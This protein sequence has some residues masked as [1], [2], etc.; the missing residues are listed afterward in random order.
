[1]VIRNNTQKTETRT[2]RTSQLRRE[3]AAKKRQEAKNSPE[4]Q[5]KR[6]KFTNRLTAGVLATPVIASL[7]SSAAL[8]SP[9]AANVLRQIAPETTDKVQ[10]VIEE[11]TGAPVLATKQV[12]PAE[13]LKLTDANLKESS[14]YIHK[15]DIAAC[16]PLPLPTVIRKDQTRGPVTENEIVFLD[17]PAFQDATTFKS[18]QSLKLNTQ[19]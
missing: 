2:V 14:M 13:A 6:Q 1:M 5:A 7:A 19:N 8:L 16:E 11:K 10:N 18:E 12:T 3:A 17:K 15:H 9:T 4:A